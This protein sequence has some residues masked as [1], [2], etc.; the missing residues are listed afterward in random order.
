M[1][2]DK[3]IQ[4]IFYTPENINRAILI[5]M[6]EQLIISHGGSL[7]GPNAPDNKHVIYDGGIEE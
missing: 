7:D 6:M 2:I 3:V 1:T 5:Q 4:Y